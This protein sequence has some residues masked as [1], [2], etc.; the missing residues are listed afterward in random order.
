[1][2]LSFIGKR[3]EL[4]FIVLSKPDSEGQMYQASAIC[5]VIRSQHEMGRR[6]RVGKGRA[7]LLNGRD[8]TWSKYVK[9]I[10]ESIQ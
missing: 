2:R 5:G 6:P 9:Y 8:C 3:L 1:M 10:Y 4:E 7:K